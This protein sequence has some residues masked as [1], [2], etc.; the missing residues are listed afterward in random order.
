MRSRASIRRRCPMPNIASV[1]CEPRAGRSASSV[2]GRD[3]APLTAED[4]RMIESLF[5]Q[6]AIAIERTLLV[7][8]AS[9]AA[10]RGRK[11]KIALGPALVPVARSA[12]PARFDPRIGH[13]PANPRR[14]N[15]ESG[16]RRSSR[17]DRRGGGAPVELR[18]QSPRHDAARKRCARSQARLGGGRRRVRAAVGTI[19]EIMAGSRRLAQDRSA[20]R[21][22]SAA[23][24]TLLEQVVFNLLDNA[25]KYAASRNARSRLNCRRSLAKLY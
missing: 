14:Q 10:S 20:R 13:Q 3:R 18:R 24:S 1:R 7:Q 2:S 11:R 8:D 15:A 19:A 4:E 25:N 16:A 17:S 12:H 6:T 5:D 21:P 23:I 9:K 22:W